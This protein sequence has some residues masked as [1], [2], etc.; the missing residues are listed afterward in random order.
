MTLKLNVVR[1]IPGVRPLAGSWS[2]PDLRWSLRGG[3]RCASS[4]PPSASGRPWESRTRWCCWTP[5]KL[6]FN[7]RG[8]FHLLIS[9][10]LHC[11]WS[12]NLSCPRR[13]ASRLEL[14]SQVGSTTDHLSSGCLIQ[15]LYP[16]ERL[17][18]K[19]LSVV[20]YRVAR[21]NLF[22]DGS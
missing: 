2:S 18:K 3:C 15:I 9:T 6:N 21:P 22:W 4:C 17:F 7:Q 20:D 5:I 19:V 16:T 1:Y 14:G 10:S 8:V 12:F 11:S 13:L